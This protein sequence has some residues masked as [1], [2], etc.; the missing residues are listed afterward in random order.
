MSEITICKV[1]SP[2]LG[3][4]RLGVYMAKTMR[5][6]GLTV[7]DEIA[8]AP[9][10][11]GVSQE[12]RAAFGPERQAGLSNLVCW[13][14]LPNH[15]PGWYEGQ[16]PTIVTMFEAS[17][18]PE[19]FRENLSE[20]DTVIVPSLHNLE[21][22]SEHHDNV[23]YV[24][25][26]VDPD[27]W[28]YRERKAPGARFN[29][30]CGGS[31]ER[32]GADLAY[33]AFRRVFGQEGSWGSGPV[34]YLVLKQPK[35]DDLYGERVERVTGRITGEEERELYANAHC[36]VQP[37]RGEGFGLQPLQAMAQGCPTILTDAHGHAAFAHHGM[38]IGSSMAKA[39]YFIY[40]DAGQWWEPDFEELCET[41]YWTYHNYDEAVQRAKA[42]SP[43]VL[44]TYTWENTCN[45]MLDVLGRERLT[46]YVGTGSWYAPPVKLYSVVTTRDYKAEIGGVIYV[47]LQGEERWVPMDVKRSMFDAGLLD[48]CCIPPD[49]TI[50]GSAVHDDMGLLPEQVAQIPGYLMRSSFCPTCDQKYGSG[51]TLVDEL[52]SQP[53]LM[54]AMGHA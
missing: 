31:G 52:L 44:E 49:R 43:K 27:R 47:L 29:F 19:S 2:F 38:G 12:D 23:H 14:S 25:L 54:E 21:L 10:L 11:A 40:G 15:I 50:D 9:F 24:P 53:G 1:A 51:T 33:R 35:P 41:M 30:L 48:P 37:S 45:Q 32:K 4:G 8:L 34:P 17:H 22:F 20:F 18:L 3:Y 46:T 6:M 28:H 26:G 42:E 13:A 7:Y 39:G 36:Y 5:E 16:I